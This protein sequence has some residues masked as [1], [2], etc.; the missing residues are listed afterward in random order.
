MTAFTIAL[1]LAA[2]SCA[3]VAGFLFA[4]AVVAM[5]G[6]RSLGDAEFIR[7]FQAMDGVIQRNQPLFVAIWL[8]SIVAILACAALG[9]MH[10]SGID[11]A[12]VVVAAALYLF[13]VQLP[14]VAVNIPLNNAVQ[15]VDTEALD[16]DAIADARRQ[17]EAR[18]NRWN[19]FRT[20][21]AC[22]V[23]ALLICT[24][25]RL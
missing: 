15:G 14:T 1:V 24:L 16:A 4:F 9:F 13:A 21:V 10:L 18:W 11:R 22:I 6:I 12:L 19:T 23:L 8:G 2:F 17:F 7:A 20:V 5:P 25:Y 3:L